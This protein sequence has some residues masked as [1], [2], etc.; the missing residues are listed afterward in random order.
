MKKVH[1]IKLTDA[2]VV[3]LIKAVNSI[4]AIPPMLWT[5]EELRQAETARAALV[6]ARAS[7]LGRSGA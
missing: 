7:S 5:A 2:E 1:T 4:P 3:S 6:L